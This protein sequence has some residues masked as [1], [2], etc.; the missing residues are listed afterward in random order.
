MIHKTQHRPIA[1]KLKA[2]VSPQEVPFSRRCN[3]KK[4][5]REGFAKS[6]DMGITDIVPAPDTMD[7]LWTLS[8]MHQDKTLP[9]AAAQD[10]SV[11]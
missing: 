6:I 2:A 7:P 4:A 5:D 10:I 11:V 9:V 3:P 1:I 8:R